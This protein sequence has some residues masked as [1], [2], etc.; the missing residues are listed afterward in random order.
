MWPYVTPNSEHYDVLMSNVTLIIG[1]GVLTQ[2]IRPT[3]TISLTKKALF[4]MHQTSK[5]EL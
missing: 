3:T 2:A 4:I 5:F 1:E